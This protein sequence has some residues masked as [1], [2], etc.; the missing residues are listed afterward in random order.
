[1]KLSTKDEAKAFR[2]INSYIRT[3]G[4]EPGTDEWN[5]SYMLLVAAIITGTSNTDAVAK[6]TKL[7]RSFVRVVAR[8]L[9]ANGVWVDGKTACDWFEEDGGVAFAADVC[10]AQGLMKRVKSKR[11]T[12]TR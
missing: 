5:T 6:K 12:K 1:M 3:L 9:R 10:V 8:R 4:C 2:Q 11:K 7:P